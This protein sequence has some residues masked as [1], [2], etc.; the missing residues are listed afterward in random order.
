MARS[1]WIRQIPYAASFG[2]EILLTCARWPNLAPPQKR[3][4][5]KYHYNAGNSAADR[6]GIADAYLRSCMKTILVAEDRDTSRE[7]ART[8]LEHSGY[9]VLEASNGAEAIEIA[10]VSLPDLVLCD[11]QMPVKTGFD[12]LFEL[13]AD[14]R[15]SSTPIVALT[16]SAMMG[17]KDKAIMQGFT[18]YLTKPLRLSII[19]TEL[20]RLLDGDLS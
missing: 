6:P 3:T 15:L 8:L 4:P 20:A 19:R 18:A 5:T 2:D 7:L 9:S 10:K 14:D 16:A 12:V 17:D 11:L 1:I 13:R